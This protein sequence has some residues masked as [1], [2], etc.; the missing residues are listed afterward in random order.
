VLAANCATEADFSSAPAQ[1]EEVS[2]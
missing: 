2:Y 1:V